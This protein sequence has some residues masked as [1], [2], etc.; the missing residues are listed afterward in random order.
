MLAFIKRLFCAH[1]YEDDVVVIKSIPFSIPYCESYIHVKRCKK[2]GK[3]I[4]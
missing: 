3:T 2:C 1:E 4:K